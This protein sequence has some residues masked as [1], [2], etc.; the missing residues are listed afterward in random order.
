MDIEK[1]HTRHDSFVKRCLSNIDVAKDLLKV[2][3][4][5]DT[6]QKINWDTLRITNKSFVKPDL[7]QHHSD[8]VYKCKLVNDKDAYLYALIEHQST[9]DPMMAFRLLQYNVSLMEQHL[10]QGH[11]QLPII[12]NLCIYAGDQSPYPYSRSIYDCFELPDLAKEKMFQPFQLAD[13]T[14]LSEEELRQHGQADLLEL[15]L[16]QGAMRDFLNWIKANKSLMVKLLEPFYEYSGIMY[17][18]GS[19]EKNDPRK[20]LEAIIEALPDKEDIIMNAAQR[21][22]EE[23]MQQGMQQG[24]QQGIQENKLATAKNMLKKSFDLSIIQEV[25]GLNI[26]QIKKLSKN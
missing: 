1:I 16:K 6:V 8:V 18:L 21:L 11:K 9:P 14:V 23:G 4:K 17:I 12:I 20:V 22:R 13:L 7:N 3:L 15:L 2:Y 25:T 24:I 19:D 26:E 5:P 10:Q